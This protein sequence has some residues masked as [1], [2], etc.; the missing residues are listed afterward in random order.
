[1]LICFV[2]VCV[3]AHACVFA[4]GF[5]KRTADVDL[6]DLELTAFVVNGTVKLY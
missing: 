3:R 1:M 4:F 6:Q 5:R 2:C